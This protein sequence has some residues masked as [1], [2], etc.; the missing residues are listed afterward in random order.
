VGSRPK[1]RTPAG[2]HEYL[3]SNRELWEE[4]TPLHEL[5]DFY[6]LPGFVRD[7][8]Q[9]RDRLRQVEV[10][11]VGDVAG[12]SLLHLMSHL[13]TD[14][15]SWAR[16][17]AAVTGVDFSTRSIAA[18]RSLADAVG[19][20]ATFV[21]ADVYD[22]EHVVSGPFD[23]IYA[24]H[25]VVGWLPELDVV[26]RQVAGLLRDGG[27]F[28]L[29]DIHPFPLLFDRHVSD[30]RELRIK[31]PYFPSGEPL[32][33]PVA[34]SYADRTATVSISK[35]FRWPHSLGELVS[36]VAEAPLGIEFLH[37]FPFMVY[38]GL[39][40]LERREDGL[41][42]IP[43]SLGIDMPLSFSLKAIKASRRVEA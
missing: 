11:E 42:W 7:I 28:Y 34:G 41:W 38:Q 27:L 10:E 19:L 17:G 33:L 29:A 36:A 16:R 15:L 21:E 31:Y 2:A 12:K 37:E 22:L 43:D 6:D 39:P 32:E 1:G 13:G 8:R 18:A 20:E 30:G 25:G 35:Q 40:F 26:A 5:S 9:G 14:T 24:S 3:R 23:V 4:W